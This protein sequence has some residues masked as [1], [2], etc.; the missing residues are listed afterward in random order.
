M[1]IEIPK[2]SLVM[3]MGATSGGKTTFAKK[4]FPGPEVLSSDAFRKMLT[5][6]ENDQSANAD[7]FELLFA[8]AEKRL[9]RGLLTVI[10]ATNLQKNA[11]KPVIEL[12]KRQNVHCVAI[13]LNP[14]LEDIL[15]R[16]RMRPD[17]DIPEGIIR[18][19]Y[20]DL[21]R[22]IKGLKKEGFRF[23][24]V[25]DSEDETGNAEIVRTKLWNDR[26]DEHGPFDIIGDVH[27]CI[28]ELTALLE[29]MGYLKDAEGTYMHPEGRKAAFIGDLCDRGPD[30]VGVYRLV[31][32]MV[33][34][35]T[36]L[37]IPGNHDD[38]LLR[39]LKGR[40]V[41]VTYGLE[42]TL[43]QLNG[44]SEEWIGEL[45]GFLD[46]LIS[47]YVLD[48][49]KIVISH[50]GLKEEYI[51]RASAR[52]REFCLYGDTN[53]ETDE[54]GT[55]VRL[56]WAADYRGEA[57]VVY[58]HTP[59][60][61]VRS[62]NR[63]W[64]IDTGCVFGGKLTALRYPEMETVSVPAG[65]IYYKPTKPLQMNDK[66]GDD[67]ECLS[68]DDVQ[69]KMRIETTLLPV[70]TIHEEQVAAAL[71]AMSRYSVD[72]RWLIYL[73]PTMSPCETA[74][75]EEYLE[76]PTEAF[77]YYQKKG[78]RR[79]ICEKKHMGSRAVIVLCRNRDAAA[80]RFGIKDGSCGIIYTRTGR[81]FFDEKKMEKEVL[82]RLDSALTESGFWQDFNTDWVCLDA[83]LMPWSE[84]ARKLL[85]EQY[86]P[87]QDGQGLIRL[88]LLYR[89]LKACVKG[90][91]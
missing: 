11:R 89:L 75:E 19:Q 84:K 55:P 33:K 14:S 63:T 48:G 35:D 20:S 4:H 90:M 36:A 66:P 41:Q 26:R 77:S 54:F 47:H 27:G 25:L 46:G 6:D 59:M 42:K 71:E 23:I 9:S 16:S 81:R 29:N 72:P 88:R 13:V 73:P 70:I 51:G 78:V 91:I 37:C 5:D 10:D 44:E 85:K 40:N 87:P 57:A 82:S 8:T 50:A 39:K 64:C 28:N 21:Q 56:D 80:Q 58:G 3:L 2:L 45:K 52:V 68:I 38:K 31:M 53:G 86:A 1:K 24:Y 43:E 18:K 79:V 76:Y 34:A 69:G 49:G 30:S 17:R 83:E 22:S 7:V 60:T 15:S 67:G 12:A 32:N 65:Q 62:I 61:E 74:K